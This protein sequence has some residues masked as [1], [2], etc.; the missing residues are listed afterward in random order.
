MD[1]LPKIRDRWSNSVYSPGPKILIARHN[2]KIYIVTSDNQSI[3][4]LMSKSGKIFAGAKKYF[5]IIKYHN[6]DIYDIKPLDA[7]QVVTCPKGP[8]R[9]IDRF[10]LTNILP[11]FTIDEVLL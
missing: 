2:K 1:I 9:E 4:F 11:L 8:F 7:I 3:I 5:D 6:Y 10:A